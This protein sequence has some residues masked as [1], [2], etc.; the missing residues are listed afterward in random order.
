M[1]T[2]VLI[3]TDRRPRAEVSLLRL[4]LLRALY[5]AIGFLMGAQI[6]PVV[7][8][9]RAWDDP[10]H[11]VGVAMLAALT[12]LCLLGIRYPLQMLPLM[13]FEFAWKTIW[14]LA[15]ALPLWRSGQLNDPAM[16]EN[17]TA[18]GAGVIICPLVIPWGYVWAN[19]G[20][21]AGDRWR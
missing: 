21:R 7:F 9:H 3:D 20:K 16:L 15:V 17:L 8:S 6:W 10:M 14:T 4:Y 1:T 2:A 13:L 18:I 19:Y 5:A 11:G 12:A